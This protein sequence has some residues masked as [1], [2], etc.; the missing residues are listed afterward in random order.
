M[1]ISFFLDA[2]EVAVWTWLSNYYE[3]RL[4][5]STRALV[6]AALHFFSLSESKLHA[7]RHQMTALRE[8][9]LAQHSKTN[10]V[11]LS[12][13]AARD[14]YGIFRNH[15]LQQVVGRMEEPKAKPSRDVLLQCTNDG[16]SLMVA[17]GMFSLVN[18]PSCPHD[19]PLTLFRERYG[20]WTP[21]DLDEGGP[22]SLRPRDDT[23]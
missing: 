2:D 9:I 22:V 17:K 16:C 10:G 20:A 5:F 15:V 4:G 7:S 6:A 1:M 14:R 11:K 23:V 18:V 19:D 8:S 21:D 3:G 13:F 12:G